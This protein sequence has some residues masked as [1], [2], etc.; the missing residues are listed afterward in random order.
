VRTRALSLGVSVVLAAGLATAF[1]SM[2][3]DTSAPPLRVHGLPVGTF[4]NRV[5]IAPGRTTV[6]LGSGAQLLVPFGSAPA[7]ASVNVRSGV[8]PGGFITGR[9]TDFPPVHIGLSSGRLRGP[10][11]ISFPFQPQLIPHGATAAETF[12]ISTWD[13]S[14]RSW[15][16]VPTTFN[17]RT[18]MMSALIHHFSWWIPWTWD[19]ARI[20]AQVSQDILQAFGKRAG[21]PS[22]SHGALP[23]YVISVTTDNSASLPLRS[24]ADSDRGTLEV[25]VVNNRNYGMILK[26]GSPV[27]WGWHS[28]PAGVEGALV[29]LLMSRTLASNELY[30]PP[31]ASSSI[32]IPADGAGTYVFHADPTA[33]TELTDVL[34]LALQAIP[35]SNDAQVA[36]AIAVSCGKF[37]TTTPVTLTASD[38]VPLV[39]SAADCLDKAFAAVGTSALSASALQNVGGIFG[40]LAVFS[41]GVT[42]GAFVGDENLNTTSDQGLRQFLVAERG[43][44]P[45]F[46]CTSEY[47]NRTPIVA[48]SNARLSTNLD[49]VQVSMTGVGSA[50]P[51]GGIGPPWELHVRAMGQSWSLAGP[52]SWPRQPYDVLVDLCALQ[53]GASSYPVVLVEN[54]EGCAHGCEFPAIYAYDT[55][56]QKY[57]LEQDLG[58]PLTSVV[59]NSGAFLVPSI[60]DATLLLQTSDGRFQYLFGSYAGTPGPIRL[61]GF[62]GHSMV[63]VTLKHP[64]EVRNDASALLASALSARP[65][66][67]GSFAA[68]VGDECDMGSGAAAWKRLE[69]IDAAQ[70]FRYDSGGQRFPVGTYGPELQALLLRNGYCKGQLPAPASCPSSAQLL[71][72]WHQDPGVNAAP[73]YERLTGFRGIHCWLNWVFAVPVASPG[74]NGTF[75]FSTLPT[76]HGL[77][78]EELT[79]MD[80]ELC[81][82]PSAPKSLIDPGICK[83]KG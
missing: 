12:G 19:W 3:S 35:I 60:S 78:T 51:Y 17:S 22:C 72:S 74:G 1:V 70:G 44:A 7:R 41:A 53:F 58:S 43:P 75:Y 83:F 77:S 49:G 2:T 65:A 28:S 23:G 45:T 34:D 16:D 27:A 24:C 42:V 4:S 18:R 47:T 8:A 21:P 69:T 20:G 6:K 13:P 76:L 38:L 64:G 62:N 46:A 26:Y 5:G 61:L 82:D 71:T 81:T 56:T 40:Y 31:L 37:L 33:L 59:Y 67:A 55:S 25:K 50:G 39:A 80:Q 54:F 36:I 11:I 32:G 10:A 66:L 57:V 9:T 30:L 14:L 79:Q 73:S 68:W 15:V 52:P 63:D 29:S 48:G